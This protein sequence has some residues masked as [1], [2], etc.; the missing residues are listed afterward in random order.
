MPSNH[1]IICWLFSSYLQSFSASGSFLRNWLFTCGGQSTGASASASVLLMN[2]QD[3]FSLGW[4]VSIFLQSKGLSNS[5]LHHSSKASVL[6]CSAFFIVQFSHPYMTIGKTIA[7]TRRSY[8]VKVISLLF[9]MLRFY[10]FSSKEQ[11]CFNFMAAVTICSDFGAQ[12]NKVCHCFHCFPIC[13]PS[14]GTE[15]YDLRF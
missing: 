10:S 3:W 14:D 9:N 7:L 2:I 4:T 8:V 1:L 5:L 12:E 13:L 15:C 11:V 6:W